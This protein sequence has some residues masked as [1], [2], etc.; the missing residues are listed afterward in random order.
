M[1]LINKHFAILGF[2]VEDRVTGLKGIVSSISFD[3]YGCIQATIT[4][5]ADK[6]NVKGTCYWH[7]VS[8]IKIL[9]KKPVMQVPNFHYGKLAEGK[10]GPA[11]KMTL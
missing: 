9:S 4:T 8:R 10:K 2:E 5:K 6:N 3:L 11:E 7:D 1:S